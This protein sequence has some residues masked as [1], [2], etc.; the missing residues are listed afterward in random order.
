MTSVEADSAGMKTSHS[1]YG[2][3]LLGTLFVVLF[4]NMGFGLY[5]SAVMNS[6]MTTDLKLDR[7]TL[8]LIFSVYVLISGTSGPVVAICINRIGVRWTLFSGSL[9]MCAGAAAMATLVNTGMAAVLVFGVVMGCGAG[10]GGTLAAQTGATRWFVRKRTLAVSIILSSSG[11]GGFLAAPLADRTIVAFDGD[12]RAG[13]W[14]FAAL[15]AVATVATALL[16]RERPGDLGQLPDGAGPDVEEATGAAPGRSRHVH[17]TSEVWTV[18]ETFRAPAWW[19][20]LSA[21]IG[22]GAGIMFFLGHGVVHLRDIG[23]SSAAAAS[24]LSV[25]TITQLVGTLG[26]GALGDR[27]EPRVLWSICLA[28]FAAGFLIAVNA[29]GT[30]SLYAYAACMGV[31]FGGAVTC[32]MTLPGNYFGA[33]A[34]PALVGLIGATSTIVGSVTAVVAGYLYDHSGSYAAVFY[35]VAG[36][37]VAGAVVLQF[38]IPPRRRLA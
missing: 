27:I 3:K 25:L 4:I 13:W 34:Y 8:G 18:A 5:A 36:L 23:Y 22:M 10:L 38:A 15:S 11:V 28:V 32:M 9:L 16:V 1:F 19:M 12:W 31:G 37:S 6:Y 26:I 24:S 29:S 21:S 2:W 17:L 33:R 30:L 20:L 7:G 35:A 14:L